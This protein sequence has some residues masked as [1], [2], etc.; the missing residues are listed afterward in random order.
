MV[1]KRMG[2]GEDYKWVRMYDMTVRGLLLPT[3]SLLSSLSL[4]VAVAV[5]AEISFAHSGVA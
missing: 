3:L 2:S 1:M 5:V 4:L